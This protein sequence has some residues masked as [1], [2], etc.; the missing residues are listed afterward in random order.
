MAVPACA[1]CKRV[2]AATMPS[3]LFRRDVATDLSY[4]ELFAKSDFCDF[5]TFNLVPG[6]MLNGRSIC[7]QT[8]VV[9]VRKPVKW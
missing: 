3:A 4:L 9:K 1:R 8:D 6:Q 7:L 5:A 2:A